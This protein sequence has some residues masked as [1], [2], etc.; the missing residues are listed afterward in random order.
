VSIGAPGVSPLRG[1][2]GTA[3]DTDTEV[4]C[5]G[6]RRMTIQ[7][8]NQAIYVTFGR[9]PAGAVV[10]EVTPELYLPVVGS[11][12]RHF[13]AFKVR[14]Q[15]PAAQLPAGATPAFAVLTPRQ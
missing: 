5:Y 7:I 3:P 2:Q 6:A 8:S 4:I 9:G 10:Y 13:D 15:T 1:F 11:I 12:T 14:A